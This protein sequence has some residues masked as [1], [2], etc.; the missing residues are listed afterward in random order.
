MSV[1]DLALLALAFAN[2]SLGMYVWSRNPSETANRLL[3]LGCL[4]ISIY[5]LRIFEVYS[6]PPDQARYFYA[7]L[8]FAPAFAVTFLC[9]FLLVLSHRPLLRSRRL[10]ILVIHGPALAIG[11]VYAATDWIFAGFAVDD[12]GNYIPLPGTVGGEVPAL[13][14]GTLILIALYRGIASL[15]KTDDQMHRRQLTLSVASIGISFAV[16]IA[17]FAVFAIPALVRMVAAVCATLVSAAMSVAVAKYSMVPSIEEL[18]R[19]E[20]QLLRQNAEALARQADLDRQILEKELDTAH[21]MQMGLMPEVAPQL[22]GL[23]LAGRCVPANRVGGD[24]HQFYVSDGAVTLAVAD[25]TGK[26]MEAAIPVVKF[27]GVLDHEMETRRDLEHRFARLNRT[28]CRSLDT[29]TFVCFSMCEVD[30]DTRRAHFSNAGCPY[31]YRYTSRTD[32][33]VEIVLDAYPL[34]VRDHTVYTV[35]EVQLAPG[36][37]VVLCSDG[38]AEATNDEGEAFGFERAQQVV[39]EACRTTKTAMEGVEHILSAVMEFGGNAQSDDV[40]CVVLRVDS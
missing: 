38:V 16:G 20:E 31:P 8:G 4:S 25:V 30:L 19:R 18:R 32:R 29:R 17:I 26:E 33:I 28:L 13:F 36:D 23:D 27:S 10:Q 3:A 40:T 39:L 15:I 12:A 37:C 9:D 35:D 22:T 24:Y 5:A 6:R 21:D 11:L 34:G 7:L 2:V 1:S 14:L